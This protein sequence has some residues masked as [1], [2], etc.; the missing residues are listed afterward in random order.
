MDP[1]E[2]REEMKEE[3]TALNCGREN[4]LIDFLY[5]ELNESEARNFQRHMQ[6]CAACSNELSAFKNV[7]ESVIKWRT[8]SL[9]GLMSPATISDTRAIS[10]INL[11]GDKP[12]AR[13]ALQQ[14]FSLSPLWMKGAVAFASVLFCL[15]AGL[16]IVRW[17]ATEPAPLA[18]NSKEPTYSEQQMNAIVSQRVQDELQRVKSSPPAEQTSTVTV[19]NRRQSGADRKVVKRNTE[20]TSNT[21]SQKARR[22]LS[23]TER[24]QLAADLRL[25]TANNDSELDLLDDT[26]NQ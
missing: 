23:K 8:E 1:L 4:D 18:N 24:Q 6:E 14:F 25:I 2:T 22:P 21:S 26:I 17:R 5:G 15:L 20:M 9:D 12:S 16:A 3:V 7:R 13:A 10:S 19:E 11:R